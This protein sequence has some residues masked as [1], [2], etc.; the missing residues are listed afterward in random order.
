MMSVTVVERDCRRDERVVGEMDMLIVNWGDWIIFVCS[1]SNANGYML[2]YAFFSLSV[3]EDQENQLTFQV[4][5]WKL[6][7]RHGII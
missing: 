5:A 7:I 6:G 2:V 3:L 4:S 1:C